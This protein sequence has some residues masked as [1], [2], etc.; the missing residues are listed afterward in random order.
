MIRAI[1]IIIFSMHLALANEAL[2]NFNVTDLSSPQ[3]LQEAYNITRKNGGGECFQRAHFWSYQLFRERNYKT[4]KVFIFFS[5]R[6]KRL[7]QG[8][9]WFHVAPSI[10]MQGRPYV[11]D[12][13]FLRKPVT[14]EAWKNGAID[15]G[16]RFLTQLKQNFNREKSRLQAELDQ[17]RISTRRAVYIKNRLKWIQ[18]QEQKYLIT[19]AKIVKATSENWPWNNRQEIIHLECPEITHYSEFKYHGELYHCFLFRTSMYYF[20]PEDMNRLERIGQTRT[21]WDNRE[22]YNAFHG[23]FRGRFPFRF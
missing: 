2:Q 9:W 22:V 8:Q 10:F 20:E 19:D 1:L 4:E 7:I 5:A 3:E 12:N 15:H 21:D 14:L 6:Y 13:E 23:A 17:R 11:L 16:I 18:A